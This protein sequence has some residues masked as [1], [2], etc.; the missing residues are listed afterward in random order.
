M[1]RL[2]RAAGHPLGNH[3][4]SHIDLNKHAGPLSGPAAN[5]GALRSQMTDDGW[6]WLR[7]PYLREGDTAREAS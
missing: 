6:R 7:Y 5:E 2:W 4:Y 3:T 1:L